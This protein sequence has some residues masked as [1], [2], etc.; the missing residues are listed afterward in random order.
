MGK[1]VLRN[2]MQRFRWAV[3]ESLGLGVGYFGCGGFR[4]DKPF[5]VVDMVPDL[6]VF[7]ME[8]SPRKAR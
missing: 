4:S 8:G 2:G 3:V 1:M 6:G 7:R 5:G